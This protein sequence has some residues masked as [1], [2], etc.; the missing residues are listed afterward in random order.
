MPARNIDFDLV[1]GWSGT[2]TSLVH[3]ASVIDSLAV[4]CQPGSVWS[5][6]LNDEDGYPISASQAPITGPVNIAIKQ[7]CINF[8]LIIYNAT[9]DTYEVRA[10]AN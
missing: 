4:Q 3:G 5:F 2:A 10:N 1:V 6:T 9:A 8:T 7:W